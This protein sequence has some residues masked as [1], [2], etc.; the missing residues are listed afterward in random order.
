MQASTPTDKRKKSEYVNVSKV[1]REREEESSRD[2]AKREWE[3]E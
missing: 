3:S 2:R 1:E